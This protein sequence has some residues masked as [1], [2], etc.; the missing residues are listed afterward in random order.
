MSPLSDQQQAK[1]IADLLSGRFTQ[2]DMK[3]GSLQYC[4]ECDCWEHVGVLTE[5]KLIRAMNHLRN[6][7]V[8]LPNDPF[9]VG[10]ATKK[11]LD[12]VFGYPSL[13]DF[14]DPGPP[15]NE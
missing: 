2:Q 5:C 15:D 9:I 3:D 8:G 12:Y 7:L 13:D 14:I 6:D 4:E 11:Q 10:M 1:L